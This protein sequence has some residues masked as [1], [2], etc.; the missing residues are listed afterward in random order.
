MKTFKQ[1]QEQITQDYPLT[2]NQRRLAN[3]PDFPLPKIG[4]KKSHSV[5]P[6]GVVKDY[7]DRQ[8]GTAPHDV[9][10][11]YQKGPDTKYDTD[12]HKVIQHRMPEV[13][14]SKN[15]AIKYNTPVLDPDP[16]APGRDGT[17]QARKNS[18]SKRVVA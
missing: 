16:D 1:F 14:P 17:I 10:L 11:M 3:D 15:P 9:P 18:N 4:L 12:T 13:I 8:T 7:P 2:P 6:T 5:Q